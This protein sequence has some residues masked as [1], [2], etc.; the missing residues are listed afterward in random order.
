[1][2]P[3]ACQAPAEDTAPAGAFLPPMAIHY[4]PFAPLASPHALRRAPE[5]MRAIFRAV[6]G[7]ASPRP[8]LKPMRSAGHAPRHDV[9]PMRSAAADRCKGRRPY[10]HSC[11]L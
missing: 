7:P 4:Y 2:P 1:M 3:I 9:E 6:S 11:Q 10:V 5:P 8:A